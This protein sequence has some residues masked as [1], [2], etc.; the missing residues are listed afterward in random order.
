ME[1]DEEDMGWAAHMCADA[2]G[3][4]LQTPCARDAPATNPSR[5]PPDVQRGLQ[6]SALPQSLEP[7]TGDGADALVELAEEDSGGAAG[8][9]T[10]AR[11]TPRAPDAPSGGSHRPAQGAH[12]AATACVPTH[13]LGTQAGGAAQRLL[14]PAK[15]DMCGAAG[16]CMDAKSRALQVLRAR[17][18]PHLQG[19]EGLQ[20]M[21]NCTLAWA[22]YR[23]SCRRL[24]A[25]LLSPTWLT[26]QHLGDEGVLGPTQLSDDQYCWQFCTLGGL[27]H[28]G[29]WRAGGLQPLDPNRTRLAC[30][31]GVRRSAPVDHNRAPS[32]RPGS[33]P[34]AAGQSEALAGRHACAGAAGGCAAGGEVP[35]PQHDA[36]A[37]APARRPLAAVNQ[38]ACDTAAA[39]AAKVARKAAQG[40]PG[41]APVCGGRAMQ[42]PAQFY[43]S[44]PVA[45]GRGRGRTASRGSRAPG[46]STRGPLVVPHGVS[47]APWPAALNSLARWCC[48]WRSRR[49]SPCQFCLTRANASFLQSLLLVRYCDG[50]TN[51]TCACNSRLGAPQSSCCLMVLLAHDRRVCGSLCGRGGC[52]GAGGGRVQVCHE[53]NVP[54]SPHL[55]MLPPHVSRQ[56]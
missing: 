50:Q 34:C 23:M 3:R 18:A 40:V 22:P 33:G 27:M 45:S 17:G 24:E 42:A 35:D 36:P 38:A 53:P 19:Q 55:S 26:H 51:I 14:E 11:L 8:A 37:P 54:A 6:A 31:P 13:K 41:G 10:G 7:Q 15:E 4:A 49:G 28:C 43:A 47:G 2:K 20:G 44:L 39:A 9:C 29:L 5:Q 21:L 16:A 48:L 12:V 30:A 25:L 1:L 46:A 56:Q 52:H 32:S